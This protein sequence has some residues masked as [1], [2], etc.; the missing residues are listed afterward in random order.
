MALEFPRG[1]IVYARQVLDPAGKNPKNRRVVPVEDFDDADAV[2]YAVAI[3]GEFTEPLGTDQVRLS[4]HRQGKCSSSLTKASV[5]DCTWNVTVLSHDVEEKTG[6][7]TN[8]QLFE[9]LERV[10]S[11]LG[12]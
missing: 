5:A 1:A 12:E 11:R 6:F 2:A 9:I 8:K 7:V 10:Q 4:F 3:T